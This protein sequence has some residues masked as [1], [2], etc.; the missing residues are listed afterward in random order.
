MGQHYT[1]THRASERASSTDRPTACLVGGPHSA[2][3]ESAL[4]VK[5]IARCVGES[6]R[7]LPWSSACGTQTIPQTKTLQYGVLS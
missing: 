5:C 4:L 6:G 3:V 1:H 7:A 2:T